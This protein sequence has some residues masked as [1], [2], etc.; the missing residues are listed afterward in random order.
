MGFMLLTSVS[1][2]S[3]LFATCFLFLCFWGPIIYFIVKLFK[4]LLKFFDLANW[5]LQ[6][7]INDIE[8]K[9]K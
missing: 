6:L 9:E 1:D 2:T 3:V 5:Y 4:K 7:K 8:H